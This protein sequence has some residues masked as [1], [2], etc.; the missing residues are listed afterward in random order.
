MNS[1]FKTILS[2]FEGA[3]TRILP[4]KEKKA[5]VNGNEREKEDDY[6]QKK[7]ASLLSL[8]NWE[9]RSTLSPEE[10]KYRTKKKKKAKHSRVI[11]RE[12]A[13]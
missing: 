11:N 13:A 7:R 6:E 5:L 2:V 10:R 8:I 9:H 4:D 1:M 3:K 12:R